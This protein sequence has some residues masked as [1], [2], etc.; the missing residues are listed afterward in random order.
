MPTAIGREDVRSVDDVR[1]AVAAIREQRPGAVGVVVKLDDS[2]AGDGNVVIDLRQPGGLHAAVT[3]LPEWFLSDLAAGGVVE[4]VTGSAVASP[5]VQIDLLPDGSAQ[6]LATHEQVLGGGNGQT[7]M[8]CRFP[9]DPAY[10]AQLAIYGE[11]VGSVLGRH[12]ARGRVSID[13]VAAKQA[14]GRWHLHALETNL[15]KGGTTHPYAVLRNL[16]PGRYDPVAGSWLA[17]SDGS[18]RCYAS[19][20]NLVDPSW[21]GLP[22]SVAID[23]VAAAGLQFDA[24]RGV[25]VVLHMLSGLGI[26]GRLGL[27]AIGSDPAHAADQYREAAEAIGRA[28]AATAR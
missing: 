2:G 12:G 1:R 24:G 22:P 19:T 9:A 14:G 4:G 23:A 3:E 27:T 7:Y 15:R 21:V 11:A 10:A 13:F 16:V 26:D 20:D 5:S 18:A 28:A 25:G 6:V 17:T 8:G